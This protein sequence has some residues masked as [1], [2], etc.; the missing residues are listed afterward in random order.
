[1]RSLEI[2]RQMNASSLHDVSSLIDD[3][4]RADG[5]RPLNDHLWLDLRDGG[6]AGFA[7]IIAREEGRSHLVGY[8]QVSRGNESWALDLIIHPHDRYD[9][10]EIGPE[11]IRAA[12][13]VVGSEGGGRVHW[14]VF[15]PSHAHRN[16]A[17]T[18]GLRQGRRLL[19][20]RRPLPLEDSMIAGNTGF[21]TDSFRIGQDEQSWLDLNNLAFSR[22]PEQGGWTMETLT[23][24]MEQDW[25]DP[26]GLRVERA[27][28]GSLGSFCWMKL[29]TEEADVLGEIY[30]IAVDPSRTGQ[31]L[32]KKIAVAG[33]IDAT[34]KGAT[35]GMLYV[36]ADN[37][38]AVALYTG[39]GFTVHHEEHS[40]IGDIPAGH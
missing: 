38:H 22:H 32:G 6:R 4:W 16:I 13:D 27:D 3:A 29:H 23:T 33:L 36:D 28:D 14:W 39:L 25:F 8:C 11:L 19:Q 37:A 17:T 2:R 40:F 35:V 7:G 5:T 12:L 34:S 30:V 26:S 21:I 1:M 31:G 20:M 18:V 10:L 9:S 24:R 15:E